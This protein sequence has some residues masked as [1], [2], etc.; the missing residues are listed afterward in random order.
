MI[1]FRDTAWASVFVALAL[2]VTACTGSDEPEGRE[3]TGDSEELAIAGEPELKVF[4]ERDH[5]V[6]EVNDDLF[7]GIAVENAA[8]TDEP[9]QLTGY[10]CEGEDIGDWFSGE[11]TGEQATLK[12]G[13]G[14]RVELTVT[15]DGASGT[16]TTPDEE[17][18]EFTAE[19]ATGSAGLHR[20][21]M[22][23]DD[24]STVASGWITLNN[25]RQ[26]G[27]PCFPGSPFWPQCRDIMPN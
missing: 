8:E 24:D 4:H 5:L 3:A 25:G 19:A 6:G 18:Q 2:A 23:L 15:D 13:G 21:E 26:K 10:L 16:V 22:P 9:R 11:L 27:L 17:P 12:T 14:T 7:I 1:R 20:L